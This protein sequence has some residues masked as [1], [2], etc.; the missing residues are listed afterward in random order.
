[1]VVVQSDFWYED[2]I[3]ALL[4]HGAHV[5]Y[6]GIDNDTEL[7]SPLGAACAFGNEELVDVLLNRRAALN[8]AEGI[9]CPISP[10]L[11]ATAKG[12]RG[13]VKKL[14]KLGAAVDSRGST[15]ETSL[16]SAVESSVPGAIDLARLLLDHGASVN[17]ESII[18]GYSIQAAAAA[19][20]WECV[21]MLIEEYG[22]DINARGGEDWNAGTALTTP[23]NETMKT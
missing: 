4:E 6:G 16:M 11:A 23:V 12:Q 7:G 2:I 18:V 15:D 21:K 8:G 20:N 13:I 10:L 17:A 19:Q 5:N 14:L 22:A 9:D 3:D 1:M